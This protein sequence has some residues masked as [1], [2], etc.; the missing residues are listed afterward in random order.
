VRRIFPWLLQTLI[1]TNPDRSQ[2][3][4]RVRMAA[5]H[6]S[7][8]SI[9]AGVTFVP[10]G[11]PV[12]VRTKTRRRRAVGSA[13][14]HLTRT[15]GLGAVVVACG[16]LSSVNGQSPFPPIA[17]TSFWCYC[18]GPACNAFCPYPNAYSVVTPLSWSLG[19]SDSSPT[20]SPDAAKIAYVSGDDILVMDVATGASVTS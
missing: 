13:L 7:N 15:I 6:C 1:S 16:A 17:Y 3:M 2:G 10:L 14:G 9:V 11:S 19:L 5:R 20:W 18:P 8:R 4:G 12:L